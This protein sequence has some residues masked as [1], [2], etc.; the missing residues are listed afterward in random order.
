MRKDWV[1]WGGCV[2]LFGAGIVFSKV[3]PDGGLWELGKVAKESEAMAAWVQAI[4]SVIAIMAAG[5]F[6]VLHERA[7]ERR[8]RADIRLSLTYIA[9]PLKRYLEQMERA[10]EDPAWISRWVYSGGPEQ[11]NVLGQILSEMPAGSMVG[12]ELSLLADLRLAHA[13]AVQVDRVLQDPGSDV[14]SI[15]NNNVDASDSCKQA[16]SDLGLA[17]E[18][19]EGLTQ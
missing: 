7:K 12:F 10:L 5:A 15:M 9:G 14:I 18:T 11:L 13:R 16:I 4:F 2:C 17:I 8:Q 19:L 3:L 1:V 6:P